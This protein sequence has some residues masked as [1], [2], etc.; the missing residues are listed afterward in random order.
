MDMFSNIA[1]G[2]DTALSWTNLFYCFLGVFLGTFVGVIPG[3]GA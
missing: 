3:I 2:L 1:L